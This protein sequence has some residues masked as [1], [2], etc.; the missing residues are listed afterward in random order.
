[1]QKNLTKN[2]KF[3]SIK[4]IIIC[5]LLCGMFILQP[6]VFVSAE[7]ADGHKIV[8]TSGN[9][10]KYSNY[11]SISITDEDIAKL[12]EDIDPRIDELLEVYA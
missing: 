5:V 4:K 3:K 11:Y 10:D 8:Y 9:Y 12:L 1:M 2:K 6:F 7:N